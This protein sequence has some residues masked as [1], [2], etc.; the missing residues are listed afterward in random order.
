MCVFV[1]PACDRIFVSRAGFEIRCG[2]LNDGG[3][4]RRGGARATKDGEALGSEKTVSGETAGGENAGGENTG[5]E[6]T[7]GR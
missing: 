5:G 4:R 3:S 1:C 6:K 2:S 7:E